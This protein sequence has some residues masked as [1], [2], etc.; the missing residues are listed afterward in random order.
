MSAIH[1]SKV[2]LNDAI[3]GEVMINSS[4]ITENMGHWDVHSDGYYHMGDQQTPS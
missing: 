3:D 2:V 1:L 4:K